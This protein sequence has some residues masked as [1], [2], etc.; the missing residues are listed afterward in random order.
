M[1][2]PQK[3]PPHMILSPIFSD[4]Q[5]EQVS[6]NVTMQAVSMWPIG[7]QLALARQIMGDITGDE[8][9][10]AEAKHAAVIALDAIDEIETEQGWAHS[11]ARRA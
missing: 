11:A 3:D 2:Y 6:R 1:T 10:R 9:Q 5:R 7:D 8:Y 4:S